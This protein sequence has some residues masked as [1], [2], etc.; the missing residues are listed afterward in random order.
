MP[1]RP[2]RPDL[3]YTEL[4]FTVVVWRAIFK[5]LGAIGAGIFFVL[6]LIVDAIDP[7]DAANFIAGTVVFL[8]AAG[9][10]AVLYLI[11]AV[12]Y[13]LVIPRKPQ[14]R[15]E[16]V[17]HGAIANPPGDWLDSNGNRLWVRVGDHWERATTLER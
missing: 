7:D 17:P 9:A 2:R 5:V 11:L 10:L 13:R 8:I 6:Y 12:L 14:P 4:Y 16:W 1:M 3:P 15:P